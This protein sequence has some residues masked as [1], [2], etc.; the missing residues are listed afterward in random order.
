ES[1]PSPAGGSESAAPRRLR[2]DEIE[3]LSRVGDWLPCLRTPDSTS[4]HFGEVF[5]E[6]IEANEMRTRGTFTIGSGNLERPA[7]EAAALLDACQRVAALKTDGSD[8]AV[9]MFHR[10]RD[11]QKAAKELQDL[12]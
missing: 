8:G 12:Q 3:A 4:K 7:G 10:C 11:A 5:A 6:A 1:L 9:G 2:R